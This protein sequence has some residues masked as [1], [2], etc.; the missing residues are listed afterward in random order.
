MTQESQWELILQHNHY[1]CFVADMDTYDL[2]YVN[3][4]YMKL[5]PNEEKVIGKKFFEAIVND[6][7]IDFEEISLNWQDNEIIIRQLDNRR[8]NIRFQVDMTLLKEE[9]LILGVLLP[10]E[11]SKAVI[12]HFE[13]AMTRCMDIFGQAPETMLYSF[14]ELLTEFYQSQRAYV[15]RFNFEENIINCV[16]EWPHNPEDTGTK[17]IGT[18]MDSAILVDWIQRENKNGIVLA[19][20]TDPDFDKESTLGKIMTAFDVSNITLSTVEDSHRRVIGVVGLSNR[21]N[22]STNFDN[23]LLSTVSKFVAQ[24][25]TK[26]AADSSIFTMHHRDGLTGMHNRV[27]YAR[28]TDQFKETPPKTVLT[29][30]S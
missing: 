3:S 16:A 18:I 24:D 15:Y 9:G 8:L 26:Q 30:K 2:V 28:R 25:V 13:T 14:M 22:F 17:D 20:T 7:V 27:A 4:E 6:N 23:R 1:P 21:G 10:R 19:D 11:E 5:L 29:P 12:T